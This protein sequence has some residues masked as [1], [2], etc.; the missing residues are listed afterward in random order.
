MISIS[1]DLDLSWSVRSDHFM[2]FQDFLHEVPGFI[3][4]L[5][6]CFILI[7]GSSISGSIRMCFCFQNYIVSVSLTL[8]L[9]LVVGPLLFITIS[10]YDKHYIDIYH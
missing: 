10:Y 2:K 1:G 4:S 3:T 8:S 6:H 5:F 7:F 9:S